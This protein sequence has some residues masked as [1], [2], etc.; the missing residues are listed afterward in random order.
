MI[1]LAMYIMNF[2]H[3]GRLLQRQESYTVHGGSYWAGDLEDRRH[4]VKR[5]DALAG[6]HR[7]Y[8]ESDA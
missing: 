8:F 6:V 2:M 1:V 7:M 5:C 3:P 4:Y